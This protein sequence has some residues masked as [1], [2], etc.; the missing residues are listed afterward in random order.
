MSTVEPKW[1]RAWQRNGVGN[2]VLEMRMRE[3]QVASESGIQE[4]P[5]WTR[6]DAALRAIAKR[7][8]GLDAVEARWIREAVR[9]EVWKPLGMVSAI[10]YLERVLGYAPRTAQERLRVARKLGELPEMESELERGAVSY[11]CVREL[12]REIGRAHV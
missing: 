6:V 8:A 3:D 4:A 7:R 9:C 5:T 2:R 10:D 1:Q 12:S 11:S